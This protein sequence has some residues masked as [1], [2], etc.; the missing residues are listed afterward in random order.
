MRSTAR[1]L[2]RRATLTPASLA[3]AFRPVAAPSRLPFVVRSSF[4]STPLR[5]SS[6]TSYS[7]ADLSDQTYHKVAD[8]TMDSLTEYLEEHLEQLS[9]I[10]TDGFDVEYSTSQCRKSG[11]LTVKLGQHGTYVVNKQPPNKQIWLSS[12]ISGP[13]R[14]D[15]DPTHRV[16]FYARTNELLHDLLDS[17]LRVTLH[18]PSVNVQ[19]ALMSA[20]DH[21]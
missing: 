7:A 4:H 17:E 18:D 15:Y 5:R 8:R 3:V 11:V 9:T 14:Y 16:W 13:K 12:P 21:E 1:A 19:E 10:D 2:L 20:V 6:P